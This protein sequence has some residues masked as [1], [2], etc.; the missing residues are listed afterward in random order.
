[1]IFLSAAI[2]FVIKSWRKS[3]SRFERNWK[4][5]FFFFSKSS[6]WTCVQYM[7]LWGFPITLGYLKCHLEAFSCILNE[8]NPRFFFKIE[9]SILKMTLSRSYATWACK[10]IDLWGCVKA[11]WIFKLKRTF[12]VRHVTQV[13]KIRYPP[14]DPLF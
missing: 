6:K 12:I 2:T 9:I 7:I 1:M 14:L 8:F 4:K 13:A 10:T 5:C 3:T 11:L